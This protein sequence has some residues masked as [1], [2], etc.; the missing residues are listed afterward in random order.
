PS[1]EEADRIAERV[2]R[3]KDSDIKLTPRAVARQRKCAECEA[4]EVNENH[5]DNQ[6]SA[7]NMLWRKQSEERPP[8]GG[9]HEAQAVTVQGGQPLDLETRAFMAPR[10]G[11]DFGHVRIH[12]DAAAASAAQAMNAKAYTIGSNIV[13]GAECYQPKMSEGRRLLA[14]ELTHVV[15]QGGGAH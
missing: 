5:N 15:Q 14:H 11:F 4:E 10:F 7:R 2:M 3:R 13:F 8:A 6:D 12:A 9:G 1:E